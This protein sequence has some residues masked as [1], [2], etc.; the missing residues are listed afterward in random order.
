MK[1]V[2]EPLSIPLRAMAAR[3]VSRLA[4]KIQGVRWSQRRRWRAWGHV[5]AL[6]DPNLNTLVDYRYSR[7]HEAQTRRAPNGFGY[8]GAAGS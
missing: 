1:F 8:V 7:R 2:D 5:Y 6:A 4:R 3:A